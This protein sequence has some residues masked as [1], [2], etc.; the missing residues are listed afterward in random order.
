MKKANG[1]LDDRNTAA[2]HGQG[3]TNRITQLYAGVVRGTLELRSTVHAAISQ[4]EIRHKLKDKPRAKAS[5][6]RSLCIR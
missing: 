2:L 5:L 3:R 1:F 6:T 4:Y